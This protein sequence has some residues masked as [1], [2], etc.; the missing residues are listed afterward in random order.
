MPARPQSP[1]DRLIVAL[2]VAD[3]ATA[4]DLVGRLGDAVGFYKIGYRLGF[5]GGLGLS[6]RL[7]AAGKQVFL[8]FKLHD[9][10]NTVREGTTSLAAAG[11]RFA[12]VHAYPQ[13]MRAAIEG[14]G[15]SGLTILAVTVLTSY[16]DEDLRQAGYAHSVADLA[17]LRARQAREIGVDGLVCSPLELSAL[18]PLIGD[19]MLLVTPGI[20]PAS[21]AADDQKRIMTPTEAIAAGADYLVVGRPVV[22]AQD[23]RA[24]ALSI[25][26]EIAEEAA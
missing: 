25:I 9:I 16:N 5:A 18:R 13:T 19:D 12:T 15:D 21:A 24:A 10:A 3:V 20:R 4:E 1:Q 23:P 8:D 22:A 26:E 17:S 14:R 11:A 2:D 7:I 6:H